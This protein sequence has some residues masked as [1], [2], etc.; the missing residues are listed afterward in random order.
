MNTLA[1]NLHAEAYEDYYGGP[2]GDPIIVLIIL[3]LAAAAGILRLL[4][5]LLE[6]IENNRKLTPA[7]RAA[8]IEGLKAHRDEVAALIDQADM[9]PCSDD[10]PPHTTPK[11]GPAAFSH[12][13]LANLGIFET[14]P[15]RF[16]EADKDR[17]GICCGRP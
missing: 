2:D 8:A 4:G 16:I 9:P 10:K 15:A 14:L 1:A 11:R 13:R 3:A 17:L 5:A 6:W 7:E 12:P